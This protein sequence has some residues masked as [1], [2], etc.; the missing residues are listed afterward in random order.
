MPAENT[1]E[2]FFFIS[3]RAHICN[4][5]TYMS[6]DMTSLATLRSVSATAARCLAQ[7]NKFPDSINSWE[8]IN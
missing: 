3:A 1:R 2:T 4:E 7:T 8:P 5:I 6:K